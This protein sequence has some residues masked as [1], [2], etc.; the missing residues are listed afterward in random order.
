MLATW[1]KTLYKGAYTWLDLIHDPYKAIL[2]VLK[3]WW[4][5]NKVMSR[6][7]SESKLSRVIAVEFVYFLKNQSTILVLQNVSF[8]FP[9]SLLDTMPPEY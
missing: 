1:V 3:N 8:E 2:H 6:G 7:I 9:Q 4:D 5:E